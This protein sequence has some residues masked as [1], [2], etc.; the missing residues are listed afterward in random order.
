MRKLA[1]FIA[2][3]SS[4]GLSAAEPQLK[5]TGLYYRLFAPL[6][7]YHN[8]A[9]SQFNIISND[10]D[11]VSQAIDQALMHVYLKRPELVKVTESEQE[12]AG[13]LRQDIIETP[14]MQ[15]VEM[16][17]QA[18]PMPETPEAAPVEV[19]IEKPNFWK[20]KGDANLQFMQ[21]YVSD[22]WYKGGESN[23]AA[24]G[25]VTLE[26]NYDNK[27]K[28]KWDNKLEMKLGFQT[29]PSDTVHKFKT[30][31]DLIRYTGKVGL[32]AANRWYYTLQMLAYTQFYHGLKSNNTKVF[33]D[34]MSPFNLSVGLGLDYKVQ[35]L[36]NKLTGTINMSPLAVNYRYVDR[37][38]L[39]ASFGVK[40]PDHSHSLTD[41][42]SQITA[43]LTWQVNDVLSWKTRIYGFSSYH[44]S[45]VEWENTFTLRVSKYISANLFL[46]PRFDD[47]NNRDENL[48]YWQFKEYS[49]LGFSYNF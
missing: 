5:N 49:S 42:G 13:S 19:V 34:F 40:T 41:F 33:S 45:E 1:L 39:A 22:N 16:V 4:M 20:Y 27:S 37:A 35:A 31:E 36:S 10:S 38:D 21:N 9:S 30:N 11:E 12:E 24:V 43:S 32:Q 2:A 3:V 17:E 25:S 15:E 6:T 7:F 47:A 44:R 8:V 14:V 23:Q 29:S 46:F 48:G 18:A 28:W 26:A